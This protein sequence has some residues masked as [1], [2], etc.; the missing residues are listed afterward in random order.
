VRSSAN[1]SSSSSS[2][3]GGGSSSGGDDRLAKVQAA[4][5]LR[6]T[7]YSL[8]A[9]LYLQVQAANEALRAQLK[10]VRGVHWL[11]P[12]MLYVHWLI[13]AMLDAH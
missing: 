12:A 13:A 3:I 1:G 5:E 11:I 6:H 9:T 2:S 7:L 4:N 8:Y 10:E